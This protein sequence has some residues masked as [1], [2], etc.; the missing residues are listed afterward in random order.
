[1]DGGNAVC[2]DR[3]GNVYVAGYT[4]STASIATAGAF[5]TIYGGEGDGF[6]AKFTASG[7]LLWA[8]YYGGN[9]EDMV[10]GIATDGFNN[11]YAE[12]STNS[13]MGIAT[14]GA[15]QGTCG[16][17]NLVFV[18]KFDSTGN[19]QWGTYFGG[20]GAISGLSMTW[21]GNQSIYITGL[22]GCADSIATIGAWQTTLGGGDDGFLAKFRL[23]GTLAWSTYYG[24]DGDDFAEAVAVDHVGNVFLCG[25]TSSLTGIA[26]SSAYQANYAGN[27]DAFLAAFDSTGSRQWGTYYGASGIDAGVSITCYEDDNIF[28]GG[29]TTSTDSIT[30]SI[31]Y[32]QTFTGT[33]DDFLANFSSS[34]NLLWATLLWRE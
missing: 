25:Y 13:N 9:G 21:D 28:I 31:A 1:M 4:Y 22:T 17:G 10:C 5:Q 24:G 33:R 30:T 6:L 7:A 29:H 18:V 16:G 3:S 34:G 12:G 2:C 15:Y 27:T 8:T 23:N 20:C 14:A 26:S 32:Q 19:R 11:I